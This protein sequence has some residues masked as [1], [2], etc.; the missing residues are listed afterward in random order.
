[1]CFAWSICSYGSPKDSTNLLSATVSTDG[2]A[3]TLSLAAARRVA[4]ERNWDLLAARSGMDAATA[5]LIVAKEFPNPTFSWYTAKIDPRG[6][7]TPLGNSFWNRNL[8]DPISAL[9]LQ[10]FYYATSAYDD[11]IRQAWAGALVLLLLITA[12]NVGVRVLTRD[13]FATRT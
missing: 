12:I 1:M 7:S 3:Q 8:A 2:V 4:F 13:R 5:Q 6:N 10:I 11:W 9:P